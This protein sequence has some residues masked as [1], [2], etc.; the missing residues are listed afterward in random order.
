MVKFVENNAQLH[1]SKSESESSLRASEEQQEDNKNEDKSSKSQRLS[2]TEE[3]F[4]DKIDPRCK[5]YV[6]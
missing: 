5:E 4:L 6:K 3:E 2:P 1:G